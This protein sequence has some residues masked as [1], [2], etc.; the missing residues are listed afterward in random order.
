MASLIYQPEK[1][2]LNPQD[3]QGMLEDLSRGL[4]CKTELV[5]CRRNGWE[6]GGDRETSQRLL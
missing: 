5:T 6:Q 2:G 1:L 4:K 3:N